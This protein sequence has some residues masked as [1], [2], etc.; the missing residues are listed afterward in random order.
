MAQALTVQVAEAVENSSIYIQGGVG[1][2]PAFAGELVYQHVAGEIIGDEVVALSAVQVDLA[3]I[4]EGDDVFID[5]FLAALDGV[6]LVR[7]S[8]HEALWSLLEDIQFEEIDV[9]VVVYHTVGL[10]I[11]VLLDE[12]LD[13]VL[14]KSCVLFQYTHSS[15]VRFGV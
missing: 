2:H 8:V 7:G 15:V 5:K 9:V 3:R 11:F 12:A 6:D 14:V 13:K 4:D 10:G 1:I